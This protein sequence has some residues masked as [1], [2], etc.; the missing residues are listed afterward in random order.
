MNQF[1]MYETLNE[2]KWL[3]QHFELI[4]NNAKDSLADTSYSFEALFT[5][6][7][8]WAADFYNQQYSQKM[9]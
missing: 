6:E 5:T 1:P 4:K 7:H 8:Q 9:K 3:P 2:H